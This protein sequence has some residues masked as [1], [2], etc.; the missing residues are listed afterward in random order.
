MIRNP[1]EL[2]K[3]KLA[4]FY[5]LAAFSLILYPVI[6]CADTAVFRDRDNCLLCHTYPTIG[7][8]DTEGN[9]RIFY[10]NG[11]KYSSSV[12]GK[13]DCTDC[14]LGINV[15]PHTE[16]RKVD[17]AKN[18]HIKDPNTGQQFSHKTVVEKYEASVH[19]RGS[20]DKPKTFPEDLPSCIYCHNNH[21][22]YN[23]SGDSKAENDDD[24]KKILSVYRHPISALR[25]QLDVVDLC[26]SCH[27]DSEKM[28]HH[29]LESIRT[30]KDTF[31]W[32]AMKYGVINAPDCISCHV[33]LG[34]SSHTIRP[35]TDPIS[36]VNITNRV[37]TCSSEGSLQSCHP[38]ATAAFAEGRVHTYGLKA[39]L[40]A[41]ERVYDIKDRFKSLMISDTSNVSEDELFHYKVLQIIKLIYKMLIGGTIGFMTIHQLLD[42]I[43]AR[44]KH[45]TED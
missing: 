18:C 1:L 16:I 40:L 35:G 41:G 27:Q 24:A 8:Y 11:D 43:R 17:C 2:N 22:A 42:Y 28:S 19:G 10:I 4:V 6:L 21:Q 15:I 12:H 3:I 13:L 26:A 9:K 33:P 14:H 23:V 7:R 30:Y 29:G 38:G 20:A 36:P 45:K 25:S 44:K 39:Q 37:K 31:H 5:I 34:Y 32:Q